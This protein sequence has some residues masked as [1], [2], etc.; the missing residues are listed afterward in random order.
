MNEIWAKRLVAETQI[1]DHVPDSRKPTIKKILAKRV[2]N[3][4]ITAT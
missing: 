2:K 4:L 3:D 1:W